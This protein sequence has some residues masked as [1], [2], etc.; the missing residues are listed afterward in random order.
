MKR[1][2][3]K[4]K[5]P[6][7]FPQSIYKILFYY[8]N[9][10]IFLMA[11]DKFI[12]CNPKT[13][14]IFNCKREQIIGQT[15]YDKFSPERQPDGTKSKD[16]ALEKI[17]LA[18]TG[19]SLLFEWM[20]KKATGE[21][22]DAEVSL[23]KVKI[24]NEYYL[25]AIVR[26]ITEK[27]R[28]QNE[29]ELNYKRFK[30]LH[31]MDKAILK[32]L[33]D[34]EYADIVVSNIRKIIL[35]DWVSVALFDFEKDTASIISEDPPD[36]IKLLHSKS[37]PLNQ[38]G[39]IDLMLKGKINYLKS[40]HKI[41][42]KYNIIKCLIKEGY[43][44]GI[45][46]PLFAH[47]KLYGSLN[48]ASKKENYFNEQIIEI[49]KEIAEILAI[50]IHQS[51]LYRELKNYSSNLEKLVQRRT[52]ELAESEKKYKTIVETPLVAIYLANADS[53]I[54]YVNDKFLQLTQYSKKEIINKKKMIEFVAENDKAFAEERIRRRQ[55][56][57]IAPDLLEISLL[58]KDGTSF[59]ALL[60]AARIY[61]SKGKLSNYLGA[62]IDISDRKIIEDKLIEINRQLEEFTYSAS[63]DLKAPLRAIHGF[64]TALL[65][66]YNNKLDKTGIDYI[67]RIIFASQKM[68]SLINDLLQYSRLSRMDIN[69]SPI[70]IYPIISGV[71]SDLKGE[72][73]SK[74]VEILISKSLPK[75]IAN[76]V[77][78]TQVMHNIISN[79]IKFIKKD[80]KP[81]IKIWSED[82]G[83]YARIY[84]Q[85]NGIGIK[86]E[87]H[88]KIF[89]IFEKLHG[90]EQYPGTGIGLAIAKKATEKMQGYIGVESEENCGSKFWLEFTK[91]KEK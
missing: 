34:K 81:I 69:L 18:Y 28:V 49:A 63:H 61:D 47:N 26:D 70:D 53:T 24:K 71:I 23:N 3:G 62:F 84:I 72:I 89:K 8:A 10:A 35:C 82:K 9:D 87:Y 59:T 12:E 51:K 66:D 31:E 4:I 44:S 55:T 57:Y 27:K 41:D 83:N 76:N 56:E 11:E 1:V 86:K 36:S 65:E 79:A 77:L 7:R 46:I 43:N 64:A 50:A 30:L 20:H 22:F 52:H 54:S 38:F 32:R 75:V 21:L 13:F 19:K 73:E 37:V 25:I 88:E 15:P 48:I 45:N 29:L 33:T 60:S 74:N 90:I 6:L 85:D 2:K 68:D 58:K 17:Q 80:T 5:Q 78:L 40:L 42:Q 39:P 16:K 91:Y 67:K 14:E